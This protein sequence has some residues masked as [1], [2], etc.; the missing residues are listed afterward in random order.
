MSTLTAGDLFV[1]QRA[2]RSY[3]LDAA[4]LKQN[5][6]AAYID[7]DPPQNAQQ[8]DLWWSTIEA[9]LFIY[10]DEGNNGSSQW[11]DASPGVDATTFAV[12][13][14]KVTELEG[15][16]ET[17]QTRLAAIEADHTTMMS[18]TDTTNGY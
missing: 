16:I 4:V 10:Y 18:S 8:G 15:I 17:L 9:N 12:Y 6:G 7:K 2:N 13:A 5:I 3:K 11:V 14:N 1:V